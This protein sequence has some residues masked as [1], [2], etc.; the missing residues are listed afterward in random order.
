LIRLNKIDDS[1]SSTSLT[2]LASDEGYDDNEDELESQCIFYP[3][4]DDEETEDLDMQDRAAIKIQA[5]WRGFC[6]RRQNKQQLACLRADQRVIMNLAYLCGKIH[7]RQMT[8]V[9]NRLAQLEQRL[10]EETAMRIAFEKAMEDMTVV[11]DQQ[12]K[13]LYDR[14]EQE[15]HMRQV[16]ESKFNAA[17]AQLQPLESRLRKEVNA[18]NKMEEMMTRV[19][20]QMHEAETSRQLH[21]KEEAES[22]KLMQSKLDQA[23]EDIAMLKK[24][25]AASRPSLVPSTRPSIAPSARPSIAPSAK[26]ASS[27][28]T[29]SSRTDSTMRRS[30]VPAPT[31]RRQPPRTTTKNLDTSQSKPVGSLIERPS[32]IPSNRR[33]LDQ[34]IRR[35]YK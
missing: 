29:K 5:A 11:I 17:L 1:C 10:Q 27:T 26:N 25:K 24:S 13:I 19:L 12:Q 15:V 18:R 2:Y 3:L 21:Q 32:V 22:K 33:P 4:S 31:T 16:Y 34:S 6:S 30:I 8:S 14:L 9:D 28:T 20:D 35:T 23:L 7:R